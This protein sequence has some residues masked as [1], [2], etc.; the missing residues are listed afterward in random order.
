VVHGYQAA[1]RDIDYVN[2]RNDLIRAVTLDDANRVIRRL[3][4]PDAFTFVVVG[5][6]EGL[7]A[8]ASN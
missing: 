5:Q 4:N 3:F 6:P 7:E 8:T 1:G 2:R